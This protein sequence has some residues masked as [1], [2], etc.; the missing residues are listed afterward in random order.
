MQTRTFEWSPH[1]GLIVSALVG[2]VVVIRILSTANWDY[3]TAR[4]ILQGGGTASVIFGATMSVV[5]S[6]LPVILLLIIALLPY[7]WVYTGR[8]RGPFLSLS[9]VVCFGMLGLTSPAIYLIG[10]IVL[11]LI[12]AILFALVDR[13]Q[14][15]TKAT[16]QNRRVYFVIFFALVFS[17][18]GNDQPWLPREVV[19]L[20]QEDPIEGY[21]LRDTQDTWW[22]I[23]THSPREVR[24]VRAS[25]I[26]DRWICDPNQSWLFDP[27]IH[28]RAARYPPC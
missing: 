19:V 8:W 9:A 14:S 16:A 23:L 11:M 15:A 6:V 5:Q 12:G 2:L 26:K 25:Q 24:H 21:V 17:A 22:Y 20:R 13:S 27:L 7:R 28:D 10:G 18:L 3:Q 4:A 1:L